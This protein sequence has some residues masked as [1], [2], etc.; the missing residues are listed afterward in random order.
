MSR[1]IRRP[2]ETAMWKVLKNNSRSAAGVV[3]RLAWLEGLT[4]EEIATLQWEYVSFET[5]ELRLKDRPIPLHEE[6]EQCLK[7]RF[8]AFAQRSPYVAISD[9]FRDAMHPVYISRLARDAMDEEE[10]LKNIRLV[11]LRHDFIIR[12]LE[13]RPGPMWPGFPALL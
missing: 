9:R 7:Q 10:S 12:Q 8:S 11:D 5:R 4:R 3:L 6:M 1:T 2:D 13:T